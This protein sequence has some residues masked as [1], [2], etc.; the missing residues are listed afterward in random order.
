MTG[1]ARTGF[2]VLPDNGAGTSIARSLSPWGKAVSVYPSGRPMVI[3]DCQDRP[4]LVRAGYA[5]RVTILGHTSI[6]ADELLHHAM[7]VDS[8]ARWRALLDSLDGCFHSIVH[9]GGDTHVTGSQ[10]GSR[11]LYR[12]R[13]G[14]VDVVSDTVH[15][16]RH[17]VGGRLEIGNLAA[18]LLEPI[19]H[20]LAQRPLLAGIVPVPPGT[21]LVITP[22]GMAEQVGRRP[23]V[24]PVRGLEEGAREVRNRLV[25]AVATRTATGGTVTFEFS[26]G[27]DSTSLG[28]IAAGGPAEITLL[29]AR[30]SDSANEDL[31][32][33]LRAAA[34]LPAAE[35]VILP[36]SQLPLTYSGLHDGPLWLNEPSPLVAGRRRVGALARLAAKFQPGVHLTGHG[37]DHVFTGVPARY[38]DLMLRRPLHAYRGLR[39]YRALGGWRTR[40]M[41]RD[42]LEPSGFGPWWRKNARPVVGT[43]AGVSRCWA[44][45]SRPPLRGGPPKRRCP[46]SP[47]ESAGWPRR[48]SRWHRSAVTTWIWRRSWRARER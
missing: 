25:G 4:V 23:E 47:T 37:G 7:S 39:G 40:D 26:G 3:G 6:T 9:A 17:L 21:G 13:V 10:Y 14:G 19:P 30:G 11:A 2:V 8:P 45:R 35:H 28:F 43:P 42:A 1:D 34:H 15:A 33:A 12:S 41:V 5:A 24:L 32:W 44:G 20:H 29:T 46:R 22:D 18:H 38:R 31:D 27:Y 16:L 36:N 48:P